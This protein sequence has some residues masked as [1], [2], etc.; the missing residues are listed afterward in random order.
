MKEVAE[1]ITDYK[2]QYEQLH[3]KYDTL[4]HEL[5]QLKKMFFGGRQERFI[6]SDDKKPG[7]QLSLGLDVDTIGQCKITATTE[8]TYTRT[9][10]EAIDNK[11][12]AHPGRMKLADHLR[13]VTVVLQPDMDVNGLKK[14]G[15]E[16]T[17]VL[18]Y[19]PGEWIV[20]QYIRAKYE[21]PTPASTHTVITASLPGRI[22]E[23]CMA[24]EGLLA[25]IM[26]DKY[27]DHLPLHR[28]LQR[29]QRAG[30]II[31]QS[32]INDWARVTLNH[33]TAL[34]LAHQQLVLSCNYLHADET[35]L[36]VLDN[37]KKGTTHQGYY[38]VYHNSK[39]K[40]VLFD[41]RPGRG[42]EGPDDM[43]KDFQGYL[44]TDGYSVYNDFDKRAGIT[45]L[46][47]MAHAR[48][49]YN[50][51]LQS[52]RTRAEYA[53]TLF[54]KLYAIE[55]KLKEEALTGEA[56][57]QLRRL[58]AI[59]VLQTLQSWMREEYPKVLPKSPIG[60]AIAY[61]LPR[62][63][64]LTIYTTDATLSID[65]N[66]IENAIR[67]VAIGKKNYLFA[68]SHD[69]AK[70]AAMIYSLFTTCRLNNINPYTWLKDVLERM[71]LYTTSNIAELLPQN[72]KMTDPSS[73]Q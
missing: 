1:D 34:Y 8:I 53:L 20:K 45:L 62:W 26:V 61:C 58:D 42:R 51:A 64:K 71:H 19:I 13:R 72:W 43:L 65:N 56:V 25:Q 60:K 46:H 35:P 67:P 17:E 22:M 9:K 23:K 24:G 39:D 32:T 33:L 48:R 12:K 27:V 68:G 2:V 21:L 50:E 14:I 7:P 29:A 3:E 52:D 57:L 69:A 54:G 38:W 59:P 16:I 41:Y 6:A 31:A 37:T 66:Q 28:Q 73:D 15:D 5:A 70:R 36:E 55:R 4:L 63:E 30:V 49:K 10:T 47:C 44:Q 11:P 40:L 18:E